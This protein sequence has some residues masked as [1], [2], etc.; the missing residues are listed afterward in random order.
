MRPSLPQLSSIIRPGSIPATLPTARVRCTARGFTLIEMLVSLTI[1]LI[2]MGAVVTLFQT[3]T[4]SV[5]G[6]RALIEL[7]D[8]M[9][10]CRNRLQT[11]LVGATATMLPPMRPEDDAGYMEIID[12]PAMDSG[13]TLNGVTVGS[14]AGSLFGDVDDVLMFTVRS[15][16]EP[17]VGKLGVTALESQTAEVI[18]F[19]TQTGNEP[20]IDPSTTP[21]PTRLFTLF[22]RVLLVA[23][24]LTS[25]GLVPAASTNFYDANDLSARYVSSSSSMVPNSLG[26]LTK[27]ENRFGHWGAFPYNLLSAPGIPSPGPVTNSTVVPFTGI[28]L[29]DDVILTNVLAFDV[30]VWDPN[31]PVLL[32]TTNNIAVEPSHPGV[33]NG[34]PSPLML[35]GS[36]LQATRASDSAV[37]QLTSYGAYVDLAYQIGY[38]PSGTVPFPMFYYGA[39]RTTTPNG[40]VYLNTGS[41]LPVVVTNTAHPSPGTYDTWSLSYE[42]DGIDQNSDGKVDGGTNGIDDNG[43]GV[44]DESG[45]TAATNE[46]DTQAPFA[47]QL[48]GLRITVRCYEPA[49]QQVREFTVVQDFLAD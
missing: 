1:T 47:A 28:R 23:P 9:R 30:Q 5:S 2:M 48:R 49:S 24:G 10:N 40:S 32:D 39:L 43:N 42:N 19:L 6:S 31:A 26:D 45:N 46:F 35:S 33:F 8:R 44:V 38:T 3:M 11:D 16:G 41:S 27:R 29:G 37:L 34:Y 22:R 36:P 25:S 20:I 15:R 14:T 7:S 12:G 4:D 17:F 13:Y 21:T 18:Y